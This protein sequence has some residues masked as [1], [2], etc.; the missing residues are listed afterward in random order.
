M[1][2]K[3]TNKNAG[4]ISYVVL[5]FQILLMIGILVAVFTNE[6]AQNTD[7]NNVEP[8]TCAVYPDV[9]AELDLIDFNTIDGLVA[10]VEPELPK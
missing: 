6:F 2:A 3:I 4:N 8:K 9:V 7:K 10:M 5:F 1:K